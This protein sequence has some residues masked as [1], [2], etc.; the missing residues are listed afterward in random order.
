MEQISTVMFFLVE[1]VSM[2]APQAHLMVVCS[3]VGWIPSFRGHLSSSKA[4]LI[5]QKHSYKTQS[6]L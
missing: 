3:Y 5:V 2:T 1:P 6:E 4:I